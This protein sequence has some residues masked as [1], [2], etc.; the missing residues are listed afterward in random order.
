MNEQILCSYKCS[1][2]A[3]V[4]F[5]KVPCCYVQYKQTQLNA[6]KHTYTYIFGIFHVR[7]PDYLTLAV[8]E[9]TLA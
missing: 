8:L 5:I 7:P 1:V 9:Q 6:L 4:D 3:W 2:C